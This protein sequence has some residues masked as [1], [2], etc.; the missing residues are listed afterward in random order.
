MKKVVLAFIVFVLSISFNSCTDTSLEQIEAN[1]RT[2]QSV[3]VDP[4]DDGTDLPDQ[5]EG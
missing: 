1:E 5:D 3:M 4:D 2:E